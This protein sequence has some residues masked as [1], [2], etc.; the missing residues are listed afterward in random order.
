MKEQLTTAQ[1]QNKKLKKYNT[2]PQFPHPN[3]NIN[4]P[5]PQPSHPL[6]IKLFKLFW[7]LLKVNRCIVW[8][9]FYICMAYLTVS[10][11]HHSHVTFTFMLLLVNTFGDKITLGKLLY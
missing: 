2:E 5:P 6:I 8:V 1:K 3:P 11:L 9:F 4:E 10:K 7:V